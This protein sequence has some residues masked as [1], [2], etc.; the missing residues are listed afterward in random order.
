MPQIPPG[1]EAVADELL[2]RLDVGKAA[3]ALAVPDE[4]AL[5][6]DAAA[7]GQLRAE[8]IVE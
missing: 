3:L 2:Q 5:V 4:L 8:G 7:I 6:L 1:I